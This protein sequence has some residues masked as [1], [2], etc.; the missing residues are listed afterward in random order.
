MMKRASFWLCVAV[1][2]ATSGCITLDG[3]SNGGTSAK[4]SGPQTASVVPPAPAP[5]PAPPRVDVP[6]V[7]LKDLPPKACVS[8]RERRNDVI[9]RLQTEMSVTGL[10]CHWK[11]EKGKNLLDQYAVFTKRHHQRILDI[12]N[13]HG[14]FL[15][16]HQKGNPARLFD[17]YRTILANEEMSVAGKYGH[18]DYCADR[19]ATFVEVVDM[20]QR[21]LEGWLDAQVK[22][23]GKEYTLCK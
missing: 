20:D 4:P 5:P 14:R 11:A 17:R 6:S 1:A 7:S 15:A 2:V 13:E 23:R 18:P 3:G 9:I 22:T 21:K 10:T 19:Y 8:E 16:K 12:Q